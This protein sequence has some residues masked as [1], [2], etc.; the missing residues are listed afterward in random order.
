MGPVLAVY[1]TRGDDPV[2]PVSLLLPDDALAE[3]ELAACKS[4]MA[5][6]AEEGKAGDPPAPQRRRR[7]LRAPLPLVIT[8]PRAFTMIQCA[9][10]GGGWIPSRGTFGR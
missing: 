3:L 4:D 8:Y 7:L 9:V 1:Q 2:V 10:A 6:V 5:G